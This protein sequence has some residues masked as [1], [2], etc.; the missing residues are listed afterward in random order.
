LDSMS[1]VRLISANVY[2][3]VDAPK[4]RGFSY[5]EIWMLGSQFLILLALFEYGF[6][7]YFKKIAK[8]ADKQKNM[9]SLDDELVK[10][11]PDLDEQIKKLDFATMIFSFVLFVL[12]A[13]LDLLDSFISL[14]S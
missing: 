7:L 11:K 1:D 4:V 5:V 2:N 9:I 10:A 14:N 12:L 13:I 6:V 3:S 8:K